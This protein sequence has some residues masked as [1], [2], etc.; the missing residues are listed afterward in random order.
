MWSALS[1]SPSA[2]T[3]MR[4][5]C[6]TNPRSWSRSGL[7]VPPALNPARSP[8]LMT[9]KTALFGLVKP[10]SLG[11][12]RLR[13]IWPPS[14]PGRSLLRACRPL[15]PRPAVFPRF[16]PSPRP[17]RIGFF[18]EPGAGLRWCSFSWGMFSTTG[19]RSDLSNFDQVGHLGDHAVS[20]RVVSVL[21]FIAR[22]SQPEGRRHR[23][24]ARLFADETLLEADRDG[25]TGLHHDRARSDSREG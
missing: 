22:L 5:R 18:F 14:K 17:T 4:P 6:F 23:P 3:L 1:T 8:T 15:V 25:L 20:G 19:P 11:M 13:G 12:R 7:T 2:R 24:G 21:A 16:P 9:A 10:R